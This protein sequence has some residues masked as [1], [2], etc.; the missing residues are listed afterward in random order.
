MAANLLFTL[1]LLM[2]TV[3]ERGARTFWQIIKDGKT[4]I[5]S[6]PTVAWKF[7][8]VLHKLLREGHPRVSFSSCELI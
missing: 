2:G 4:R 3:R 6:H 7:C 5:E 8:H 1:A